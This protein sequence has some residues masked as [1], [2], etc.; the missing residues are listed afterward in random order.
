MLLINNITGEVTEI[1]D[2]AIPFIEPIIEVPK[3]TIDELKEEANQL[4]QKLADIIQQL[5][6]YS[7]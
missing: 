6:S 1:E 3:P 5:E 2:I 7:E 4:T